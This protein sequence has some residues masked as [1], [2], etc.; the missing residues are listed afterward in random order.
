LE[1][2]T[3]RPIDPGRRKS[4]PTSKKPGEGKLS[5]SGPLFGSEPCLAIK[6]TGKRRISLKLLSETDRIL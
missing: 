5:L 3:L 1:K 6:K 4:S 2:R